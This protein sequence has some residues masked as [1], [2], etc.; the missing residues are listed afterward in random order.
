MSASQHGSGLRR[1]LVGLVLFGISFGYVEAAV[2][3]YLRAIY[4]P[5]RA[6][7]QPGRGSGDLFP[8]I[9]LEQLH[10]S[11]PEHV[12]RLET[13]L[14]REVSTLVL[15][16]GAALLAA[17]N[18]NEWIAAFLIAFGIWDIFYYV[19]LKLLICWPASL[20]TWDILFL[21][22]LPWVG[23]VIA[24]VLVAAVMVA[25]GIAVLW[26]ERH[27][28]PV[29]L[30]CPHWAVII[31]G[32]LVIVLSFCWD[33]RNITAGGYPQSFNWPLYFGGLMLGA[34]G[35]LHAFF[36]QKHAPPTTSATA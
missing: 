12:R 1:I 33:W 7:L 19:F 16:T 13:E 36:Q 26:R 4:D 21:I 8:L 20:M 31:A 17:R 5:I 27:G 15:L 3:A 9:R 6:E 34:A 14:G 2:V 23:P 18:F 25:S 35:F 11:G 10:A 22:P 30:T 28:R 32:G 24:P 29:A